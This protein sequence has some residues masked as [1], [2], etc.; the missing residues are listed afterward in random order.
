M[1]GLILGEKKFPR[2]IL[3]K[4]KKKRVKYLII[5]LTKKR[6]SRK[7]NALTVLP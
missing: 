1:I 7:I 2:E 5:D 6:F 4:V 3:R